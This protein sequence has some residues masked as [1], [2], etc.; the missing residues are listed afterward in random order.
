M[1]E[2]E[3]IIYKLI[4]RLRSDSHFGEY[5]GRSLFS[6]VEM[7]RLNSKEPVDLFRLPFIENSVAGFVGYKNN[8]FVI[9]TN[10]S[11]TLGYEIFTLA[12]EIYHLFENSSEIKKDIAI[13]EYDTTSDDNDDIADMFA[14]ELLMPKD[15]FKKDYDKLMNEYKLENPNYKLIIELQQLYFVEYKAVINR[16]VELELINSTIKEFLSKLLENKKDFFNI[17]RKLG[18][19]NDLN[20]ASYSVNLPKRFLKILDDNYNKKI[21][22]FNDLLVIFSYCNLTPEDFGYEE[23]ELLSEGAKSLLESLNKQLGSDENGEE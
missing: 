11:K 7:I 1:S 6:I 21:A 20:E 9:F 8:Q 2:Y 14:S 4:D 13:S 19:S 3:Q 12:H 22:S 23:D 10:T 16:L 18:Y 17:T 5:C 15:V